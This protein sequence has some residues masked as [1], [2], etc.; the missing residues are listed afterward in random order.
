MDKKINNI[1]RNVCAQYIGFTAHLPG[2][3]IVSATVEEEKLW[4]LHNCR[5]RWTAGILAKFVSGIVHLA[6]HLANMG[7]K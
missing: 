1:L 5:R 2:L 3:K 7:Q 4:F 6:I